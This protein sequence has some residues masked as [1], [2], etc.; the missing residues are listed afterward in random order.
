[1]IESMWAIT[2]AAIAFGVHVLVW[3]HAR[4]LK[5]AVGLTIIFVVT[6]I[7]GLIC[8]ESTAPSLIQTSDWV[9]WATIVVVYFGLMSGYIVTYPAVEVDSPTLHMFDALSGAGSSGMSL[10][11]IQDMLGGRKIISMRIRDLLSEGFAELQ[12]EKL[13]LS[14]RG[15][16][17]AS[18]F[19]MYR[20]LIR[21]SLGG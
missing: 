20:R 17:V 11:E 19:Y 9:D 5:S 2:M 15:K 6:L 14:A 18:I 16:I 10:Q 7:V 13:I 1:M 4:P 3:R 21:R 8:I 12:G